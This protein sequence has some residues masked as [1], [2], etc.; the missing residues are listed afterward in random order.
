MDELVCWGDWIKS[1][2]GAL[3]M[4]STVDVSQLSIEGK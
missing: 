1:V 4:L 3:W 2:N